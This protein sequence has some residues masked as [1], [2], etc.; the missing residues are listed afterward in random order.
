MFH[1]ISQNKL[2]QVKLKYNVPW[3]ILSEKRPTF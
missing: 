3:G 2:Y 1:Y